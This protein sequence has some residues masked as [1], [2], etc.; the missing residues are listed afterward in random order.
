M[1]LVNHEGGSLRNY[2]CREPGY[3]R[4]EDGDNE[5]VKFGFVRS[6]AEVDRLKSQPIP[7]LSVRLPHGSLL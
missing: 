4:M 3:E 6:S 5:G 1:K 2:R 7:S